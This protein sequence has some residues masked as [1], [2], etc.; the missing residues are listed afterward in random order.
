MERVCV[1]F[2][3]GD[4]S[5][6]AMPVCLCGSEC[7]GG[8]KLRC[9]TAEGGADVRADDVSARRGC[10][11]RRSMHACTRAAGARVPHEAT[12]GGRDRA[13]F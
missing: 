11:A 4:F 3:V 9:G 1:Y 13:C 8:W 5:S 10:L 2:R 12:F 7:R 6:R